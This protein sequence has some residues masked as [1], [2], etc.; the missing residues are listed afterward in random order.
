MPWAALEPL[1]PADRERLITEWLERW[2]QNE[3]LNFGAFENGALVGGCGLH[4]R[5]GPA[6]LRRSG[7]S[8]CGG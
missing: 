2:E 3:D 1:E 7:S 8:A 4:R 6:G 5:V